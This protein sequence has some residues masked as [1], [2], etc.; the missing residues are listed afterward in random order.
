MPSITATVFVG[1][2]C[3]R[4][5][6]TDRYA[7]NKPSGRCV[8]CAKQSAQERAKRLREKFPK[9]QKIFEGA[10]C[11]KCGAT[12]RCTR[13]AKCIACRKRAVEKHLTPEK[14]KAN[15]IKY[16]GRYKQRTNT[17]KLLGMSHEVFA[18][19]RDRQ[20]G[21][22]AICCQEPKN[23]RRLHIDHC[24]TTGAFRGLLCNNCNAGIGMLK[25]DPVIVRQA[26]EYLE[27]NEW[28]L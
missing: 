2:P 8:S 23:G 4:C 6:D 11:V 21:K 17:Q 5:G 19:L 20:E 14:R 27:N 1:K 22:C 25:D 3:V 18:R 7:T 28:A 12:L 9:S 13:S 15:K 24:H 10:P 16:R 26:L